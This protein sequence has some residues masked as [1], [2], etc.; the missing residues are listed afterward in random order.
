MSEETIRNCKRTGLE[1]IESHGTRL[2]HHSQKIWNYAELGLEEEKSAKTHIDFLTEEGFSTMKSA[3]GIPTAFIS[4][5]GQGKPVIGINC[6]Y[7]ALPGLSQEVIP[8]KQP[9][10]PGAPGHGCGHNLLGAG[11]AGAAAALKSVMEKH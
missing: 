11:G 4:T 5:W 8:Q 3:A 7:D 1:W 9:V 10:V 6:E 2:I